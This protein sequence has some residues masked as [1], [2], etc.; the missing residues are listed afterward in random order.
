MDNFHNGCGIVVEQ[1]VGEVVCWIKRQGGG[2]KVC[3]M[4]AGPTVSKDREE[5]GQ[6]CWYE[7]GDVTSSCS[8]CYSCGGMAVVVDADI[9]PLIDHPSR[10]TPSPINKEQDGCS[11]DERN[12]LVC[13]LYTFTV[14]S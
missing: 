13:T 2:V 12:I 6:K 14:L 9:L 3:V 5:E 4:D 7:K 10:F 8:C 11:T 1:I